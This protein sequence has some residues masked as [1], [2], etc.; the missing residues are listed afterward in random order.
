M[1]SGF[2]VI[3]GSCI[4]ETIEC[5]NGV[6]MEKFLLLFKT[7]SMMSSI[8]YIKMAFECALQGAK[9]R[10][11]AH[12]EHLALSKKIRY[13]EAKNLWRIIDLD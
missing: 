11:I 2:I 6:G 9:S 10:E 4:P 7:F 12:Q 1:L 3:N 13:V 5:M 8:C